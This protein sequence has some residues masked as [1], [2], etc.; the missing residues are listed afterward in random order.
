[1]ELCDVPGPTHRLDGQSLLPNLENPTRLTDRSSLTV[2]DHGNNS[3]RT[4]RWRYIRYNEG[5][6]E[7][8]DLKNDP[9]EWHNLAGQKKHAETRRALAEKL[10]AR[11]AELAN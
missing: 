1:M 9:N 2:F 5:S 6:E 3:L 7:L 11:L 8:Y 4:D 10:E